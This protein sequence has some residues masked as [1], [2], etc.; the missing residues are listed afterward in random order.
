MNVR[1][2]LD[3]T[4]TRLHAA[5]IE[6]STLESQYL[7]ASALQ[8][9]RLHVFLH[10]REPLTDRAELIMNRFIAER[11]QRKPLSYILGTQPFLSIE[12]SV[13]PDV[14]IPRPETELLVEQANRLLEKLPQAR[15][16]DVGTGSGNIAIS[17]AA[18]PHVKQLLGIDI[19]SNAL[20]MA[21]QNARAYDWHSKIQWLESDLLL[22]VREHGW[23]WFEMIVANLPYIR[24][25]DIDALEPELHW[26]PRLAL[27]G[28]ADGLKVI[29]RLIQQSNNRLWAGGWLVLEIGAD[30]GQTVASYLISEGR[31][32]AITVLPDYAGHDRI[33]IAQ[34]KD[35]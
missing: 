19:S 28:G 16:A 33:V 10:E 2:M 32:Q 5:G 24:T 23:D 18:H 15:V 35:Y 8:Q 11:V 30:Q 25:E 3:Y 14:L 12:L 7:L 20:Q 22:S 13:T 6:E 17:L 29:R 9:P 34:R 1:E 26:E 21:K 27:D 4:Q 31:W